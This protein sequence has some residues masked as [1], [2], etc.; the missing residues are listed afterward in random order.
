MRSL[1]LAALVL[2]A[3]RANAQQADTF[4]LRTFDGRTQHVEL[5][6]IAVPLSARDTSRV[7]LSY[8]RFKSTSSDPAS[9]IVF[10][11]GG[12]GIPGIVMGQVP[13]YFD[14]FNALARS[15]DVFLLDQRGTGRSEPDVACRGL[16]L[17][18]SLLVRDSTLVAGLRAWAHACVAQVRHDPGTFNTMR[19]ADDVD[20]L[21]NAIGADR[22][23]LLAFSYGGEVALDYMRRY[24]RH[25]DRVVL[26]APRGTNHSLKLPSVST[27]QLTALDL[28][29]QGDSVATRLLPDGLLAGVQQMLN[30]LE[31]KPVDITLA[32]RTVW[33]GKAGM[34]ALIANSINDPGT[35]RMLPALVHSFNNGDLRLTTRLVEQFY[36]SLATSSAMPIL[37]NCASGHTVERLARVRAEAAQHPLGNGMNLVR[38]PEYC[39]GITASLPDAFRQ[40]VQSDAPVLIISG[41]H[42]PNAPALAVDDIQRPLTRVARITVRNGFHETLPIP[43][44]QRIVADFL[45]GATVR[46]RVVDNAPVRFVTVEQALQPPRR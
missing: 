46:D 27:L 9:P 29:A 31:Q 43:D 40:P 13:P 18:D 2:I 35:V 23:S 4:Q 39:G 36:R 37:V 20:A 26:A 30:T 14:L 44:V 25:V 33:L 8:V 41:S 17:P 11:A 15:A 3:H 34:Q 16:P 6:R 42:D 7:L 38:G 21:R 5:G 28:L 19:I 45:A 1:I 32:D 12:P 10:L 24:A 22:L